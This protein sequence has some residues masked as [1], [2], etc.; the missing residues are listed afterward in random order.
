MIILQ[1]VFVWLWR[2]NCVF[3][4]ETDRMRVIFITAALAAMTLAAI[5]P[6]LENID[7]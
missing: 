6:D 3:S 4:T 7:L 2:M 5:H 1:I